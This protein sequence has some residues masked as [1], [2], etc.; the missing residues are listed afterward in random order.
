VNN[1]LVDTHAHLNF[2]D[3]EKDLDQVIQRAKDNGV[4]KI[5]CAS[6][7]IADSEKALK[8]ALI[9][10]GVVYAA[11]GIHPQQTDPTETLTPVEQITRLE[12]LAGQKGIVAIGECG[13]DFS[14]AP[15]GEKDRS[16]EEQEWLFRKQVEIAVKYNLPL[17]I[18]SREAFNETVTLLSGY[19]HKGVIHCYTGG[20]KG[21]N[22]IEELGFFF[23][24]DGNLT[25]DEGLMNVVSL[26]P[27]QKIILETDSPFLAPV[28]HRGERNEPA[29]TKFTADSLAKVKN[30]TFNEAAQVIS[31]NS[32]TLFKLD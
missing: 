19:N 31:N 14:P 32:Q 23:G 8:L 30:V 5:I 4:T 24:I 10:P 2:P 22:K 12:F 16:K 15:P 1:Y 9:Y 26:I 29:Y 11:V 13:F 20:K 7:N 27:L 6:S 25:Y 21:I 17:I 18:H 28:P 3:F